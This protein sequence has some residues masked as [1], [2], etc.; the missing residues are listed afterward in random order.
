MFRTLSPLP[1]SVAFVSAA[2]GTS[3][4]SPGTA[5]GTYSIFRDVNADGFVANSDLTVVRAF[6]GTRIPSG[7]P[8]PAAFAIDSGSVEVG[9]FATSGGMTLDEARLL[10]FATLANETDANGVKKK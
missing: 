9:S 4:S 1:R 10:A 7:E 6:L 8:T 3:T 2:L 5:P